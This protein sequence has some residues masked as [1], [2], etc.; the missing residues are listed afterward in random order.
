MD[1]QSYGRALGKR[2]RSF[3]PGY[4]Y[5]L[6]GGM[7]DLK[8]GMAKNPSS[9]MQQIQVPFEK[10]LVFSVSSECMK[11][12]ESWFH[13]WFGSE[14]GIGEWFRYIDSNL[15]DYIFMFPDTRSLIGYFSKWESYLDWGYPIDETFKEALEIIAANKMPLGDWQWDRVWQYDAQLDLMNKW[16]I[17]RGGVPR[18]EDHAKELRAKRHKL[19]KVYNERSRK[20]HKIESDIRKE[21]YQR[22]PVE[23]NNIHFNM[24][25]NEIEEYKKRQELH[26]HWMDLL[27]GES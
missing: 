18:F 22:P 2:G 17:E 25:P 7:G 6:W 14:R 19:L 3:D 13:V 12:D 10:E 4:I 24:T 23:N 16:S 1:I 15:M 21:Y 26:Q 27:R 9:R 20:N 5:F 11:D 8:I